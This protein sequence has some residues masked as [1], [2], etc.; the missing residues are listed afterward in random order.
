MSR[1]FI[2]C[3]YSRDVILGMTIAAVVFSG[4]FRNT[5]TENICFSPPNTKNIL[6]QKLFKP[7][8]SSVMCTHF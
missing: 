2:Q 4:L 7:F 3:M 5:E 1:K 8:I 6:K